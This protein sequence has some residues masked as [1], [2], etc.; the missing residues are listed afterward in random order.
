MKIFNKE[1]FNISNLDQN[2][3]KIKYKVIRNKYVA[4]LFV[5][6]CV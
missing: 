2:E 1:T 5:T 4:T 6:I 3:C